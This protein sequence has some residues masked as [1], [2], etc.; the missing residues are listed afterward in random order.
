MSGAV[1]RAS[2]DL[3]QIADPI[4]FAQADEIEQMNNDRR[5]NPRPRR[6]ERRTDERQQRDTD[7]A[8]ADCNQR[9]RGKGIASN[10]DCRIP[11]CVAG[12]GEQD[13]REDERIQDELYLAKR[14]PAAGAGL[15]HPRAALREL[16][17]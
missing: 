5:C 15:D 16:S 9:R 17:V 13:G 2:G 4:T 12:S 7:D 10:L 6:C 3:T 1:P 8:R 11:A 14:L